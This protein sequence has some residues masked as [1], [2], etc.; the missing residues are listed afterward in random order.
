LP[1]FSFGRAESLILGETLGAAMSNNDSIEL[2]RKTLADYAAFLQ[3]QLEHESQ[4]EDGDPESLEEL[5]EHLQEVQEEQQ[6]ITPAVVKKALTVYA[7]FLQGM[8]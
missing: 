6:D 7:P 5:E 1:A 4:R 3:A 8:I 2:A